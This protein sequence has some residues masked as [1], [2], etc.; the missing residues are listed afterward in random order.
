VT[1]D[2]QPRKRGRKERKPT[3]AEQKT[4]CDTIA[5][6]G[7][8]QEAFVLAGVPRAAFYRWL[9][10]GEEA[11]RAGRHDVFRDFRDAVARARASRTVG[12]VAGIRKAGQDPKH[13]Q[14]LAWIAE[15]TDPKRFGLRI[16]VHVQEEL[17]DAI[18]RLKEA[19]RDDPEGLERALAAV[20]GG[21]GAGGVEQDPG[22]ED[23]ED[24]P[25]GEAVPAAPAKPEA[26]A[27]PESDV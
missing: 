26:I 9:E 14:A 21:Y 1:E 27:V 13:W 16:R 11:E 7:L 17:R 5:A 25:G 19:F 8:D 6:T 23:G 4:I 12:L 10:K 3:E 22:G 15:R 24:D 2:R 20:A 18:E